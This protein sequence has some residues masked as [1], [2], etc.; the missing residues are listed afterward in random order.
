VNQLIAARLGK[1]YTRSTGTT[2]RRKEAIMDEDEA[3]SELVSLIGDETAPTATDPYADVE[4]DQA[5]W[6]NLGDR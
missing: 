2:A 6:H 4:A 3:E 1:A 5:V